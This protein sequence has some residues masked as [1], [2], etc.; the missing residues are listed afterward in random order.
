MPARGPEASPIQKR[1]LARY[2]RDTG[3]VSARNIIGFSEDGYRRLAPQS[4]R[5]ALR[6][7]KAHTNLL[8][9]MGADMRTADG[10]TTFTFGEDTTNKG[11]YIYEYQPNLAHPATTK[12]IVFSKGTTIMVEGSKGDKP[13]VEL[14]GPAG[15]VNLTDARREVAKD[16]LGLTFTLAGSPSK[17]GRIIE[18]RAAEHG[19]E[20][21]LFVHDKKN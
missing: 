9:A 14:H 1:M 15:T 6:D 7:P 11:T 17:D 18:M 8:L 21:V 16:G 5:E 20:K 10:V 12:E 3:T 4:V 2:S 19:G 13:N